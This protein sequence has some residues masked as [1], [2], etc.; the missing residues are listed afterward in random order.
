VATPKLYRLLTS[1][2]TVVADQVRLATTMWTRFRGLMM[3][4][5]LRPG[6][7]LAI[8]PCASIHMFFMRMAID[9]AFVDRQGNVMHVLNSIRPWRVSRLV[10]GARTAIELEPGVLA[11]HGV[12]KGSVLKL[13]PVGD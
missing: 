10:H 5:S 2:G 4:A 3:V 12:T 9:V 6:E 7:G 13:V 8:T 1:D 11:R